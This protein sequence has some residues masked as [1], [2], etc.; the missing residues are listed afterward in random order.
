[1][2]KRLYS[3]NAQNQLTHNILAA[4]TQIE[5]NDSNAFAAPAVDEIEAITITDGTNIE[6]VHCTNN[7]VATNTLTVIRAQEGTTD[8]DFIADTILYSSLTSKNLEEF[9]DDAAY[10]VHQ[11][12]IANDRIGAAEAVITAHNVS[13]IDHTV[14]LNA[15]SPIDDIL[16]EN[17]AI[18]TQNGFVLVTN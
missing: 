9:R 6:I 2:A 8:F 7:D 11:L 12:G 18:L 4:D 3:N 15:V 13:I 16:V 1:M 10:G 5:V 17:D 14:A